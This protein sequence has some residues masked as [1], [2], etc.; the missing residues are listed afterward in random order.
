MRRRN[1]GIAIGVLLLLGLGVFGVVHVAFARNTST[2]VLLAAKPTTCDD[3]FRILKLAPSLITAAR[4]V[5]LT[6]ALQIT[7]ELHGSVAQAYAIGATG[8]GPT[9]MC[10]V[11]KRWA[12]F[13]Q[14]RLAV[15]IGNKAYRLRIS[16]P[17]NSAHQPFTINNLGGA[18]ELAS[19]ADPNADW[20]QAS[21]TLKLNPDGIT[22]SIDADLVRDVAGAKPVHI[23]GTWACGA[24][25]AKPAPDPSVPCSLFY[26][27][28]QLQAEDLARIKASACNAQD[29]TF[30]GDVSGHLD[31]AITD[32]AIQRYPG[33]DGDGYCNN[34]GTQYI[35]SLKFSIGDET[36]M[37]V[38]NPKS[39][40]YFSPIGPGQ[41]SAGKSPL[42]ANA[43]LWLG[44][45]DAGQNGRFVA[46]GGL[47]SGVWW[48]GSQ[49]SFTIA[50]DLKSGTIDETFEGSPSH[51]GSS[52][53]VSG[54]WRCAA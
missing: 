8:V 44:H 34:V 7:G 22:G 24:P 4:P 3:S 45:A 36:F 18:V 11:P 39:D 10:G 5:C 31:H 41:Y 14:A 30:N 48:Y 27:L 29:L 47:G 54:S 37:L 12:N 51:S 42:R 32:T 19:I 26:A 38:F 43:Y 15:V 40:S 9:Q 50:S 23:R 20:N 46:D 53:H 25:F 21:G 16:A 2:A 6:Q 49:G 17:G 52:V 35:A 1:V 28:N 33:I 13:P